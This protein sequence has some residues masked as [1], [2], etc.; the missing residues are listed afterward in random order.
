M[1]LID[2]LLKNEI[3]QA[4]TNIFDTF[5]RV[6]PVTFFKMPN[7]EVVAHDPNFNGGFQQIEY[8]PTS[9]SQAVSQSFIC[10][11]IYIIR[12]DENTFTDS[13]LSIDGKVLFNRIKIQCKEDAFDYLKDT[14][15]FIF[16]DE[17]Y[18]IQESWRRI[19]V[20]GTFQHYEVILGRIV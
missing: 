10:R 4:M 16:L 9:T 17:R 2:N 19:G 12:Q 15:R 20:L 11:I 3:T 14:E 5:A 1:N 6:E 7:S 8:L 13:D 18:T